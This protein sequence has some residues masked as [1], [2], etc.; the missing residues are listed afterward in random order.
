METLVKRDGMVNNSNQPNREFGK[1]EK[2]GIPS[3]PNKYLK[4]LLDE[5]NKDFEWGKVQTDINNDGLPIF[6]QK[7]LISNMS[8]SS[9]LKHLTNRWGYEEIQNDLNWLKELETIKK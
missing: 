6:L 3:E 5:L 2:M 1:G 7:V 4:L 9:L 8:S